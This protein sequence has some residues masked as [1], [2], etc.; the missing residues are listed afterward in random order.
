MPPRKKSK[1]AAAHK[2]QAQRRTESQGADYYREGKAATQRF[3]D[4]YD[5]APSRMLALAALG[6]LKKPI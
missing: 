3:V 6:E 1:N 5:F 2:R 4:L